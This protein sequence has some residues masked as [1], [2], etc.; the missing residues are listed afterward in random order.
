[1]LPVERAVDVP[2]LVVHSQQKVVE[3]IEPHG[4]LD[5]L[6]R[7]VRALVLDGRVCVD[8]EAVV[9]SEREPYPPDALRGD[10]RRDGE[11]GAVVVVLL[12]ARERLEEL[13][14]FELLLGVP[15]DGE[16][17]RVY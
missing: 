8:E 13:A 15:F 3:D 16:E 1:M 5:D 2:A 14:P 11:C 12:A 7:V 17:R 9:V 4:G 6:Q 10:D